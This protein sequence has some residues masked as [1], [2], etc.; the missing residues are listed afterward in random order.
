M[1][2]GIGKT[3]ILRLYRQ[4]QW[5][6]ATCYTLLIKDTRVAPNAQCHDSNIG[7]SQFERL[8]LL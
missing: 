8:T 5:Y 1:G 7:E 6:M 2:M 3:N 4:C